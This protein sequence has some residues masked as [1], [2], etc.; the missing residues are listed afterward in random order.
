VAAVGRSVNRNYLPGHK[1]GG[2]CQP[3]AIDELAAPLSPTCTAR[4]RDRVAGTAAGER[5]AYV[6]GRRSSRY[7]LYFYTRA[8][9]QSA[10]TMTLPIMP[11]VAIRCC[12][13]NRGILVPPGLPM[14]TATG[15]ER[16][17]RLGADC[18]GRAGVFRRR[19]AAYR[20]TPLGEGETRVSLTLEYLTDPRM[21]GGGA[22]CQYEGFACLLRFRQVFR[23]DAAPTIRCS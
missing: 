15:E 12:L 14:H 3:H 1:Q 6:A 16:Q 11:G 5:T 21:H 17:F 7:A 13:G 19:C 2:Q 22:S 20:I 4:L 18:P 10:G 8:G 23:R 9:D